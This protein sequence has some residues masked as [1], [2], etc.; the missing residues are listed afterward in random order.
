MAELEE[1][2]VVDRSKW[3][4]PNNGVS[5][6]EPIEQVDAPVV[7]TAADTTPPPP[8]TETPNTEPPKTDA[9]VVEQPTAFADIWKKEFGDTDVTAVKDIVT[10]YNAIAPE[11]ETLKSQPPVAPYKT[12]GGKQIDEWLSNGVKLE[13]IA[14][15]HNVKA[16]ALNAEQAIKLRMEIE[17][18]TW[19]ADIID[20]YYQTTYKHVADELKSD[21]VNA[22]E[23]KLKT[24]ALLKAEQ[25]AKSFLSGYL[26]KQFNQS[27]VADAAVQERAANLQ[28]ATEFW[29]AQSSNIANTVKQVNQ[30]LTVK[31]MSEKG[32]EE[33]K[34]PVSFVIP[35]A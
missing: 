31:V 27:V 32:E 26:D 3:M 6:T 11:Y 17:N 24:G 13:T 10:K 8:S 5:K 7:E 20:A 23:E 19:D 28:K 29:T 9:P 21:E 34:L 4:N 14:K 15:F 30:E 18:P 35:E 16:D 1:P 25:E 2:I 22:L 12:D 33:V